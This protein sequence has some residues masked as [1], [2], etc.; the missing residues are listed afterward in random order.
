MSKVLK[1]VRKVETVET[2]H[3]YPLYCYF[4]GDDCIMKVG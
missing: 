3:E 1:Y 2:E 4:Q